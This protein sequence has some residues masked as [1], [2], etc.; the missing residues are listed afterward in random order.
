MHGAWPFCQ[1]SES[2]EKPRALAVDRV[3]H[4]WKTD[5]GTASESSCQAK[6]KK[7]GNG[8]GRKRRSHKR[9]GFQ[10]GQLGRRSTALTRAGCTG[11]WVHSRAW[12][13]SA[14]RSFRSWAFFKTFFTVSPQPL[15]SSVS[16]RSPGEAGP[17]GRCKAFIEEQKQEIKETFDLFDTDGSGLKKNAK[18][19]L[20]LYRHIED[21]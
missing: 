1:V 15:A 19:G 11:G 9:T 5:T 3:R 14:A 17:S 6:D 12:A 18:V 7:T 20:K 21:M 2:E 10:S 13:A 4:Y 8:G 16:D